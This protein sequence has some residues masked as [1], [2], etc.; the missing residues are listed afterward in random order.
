M[1]RNPVRQVGTLL[2]HVKNPSTLPGVGNVWHVA[3]SNSEQERDQ[4]MAIQNGTR[5][6]YREVGQKAMVH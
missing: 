6:G 5:A 4:T 1:G 2:L 3:Y